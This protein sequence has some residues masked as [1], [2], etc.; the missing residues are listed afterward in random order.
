M[1]IQYTIT[2][3]VPVHYVS[4]FVSW[5]SWMRHIGTTVVTVHIPIPARKMNDSGQRVL[6]SPDMSLY[7]ESS[8]IST[9]TVQVRYS[10]VP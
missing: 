10:L 9:C 4:N 5:Q 1:H 7:C 3:V 2:T 8:I 6:V